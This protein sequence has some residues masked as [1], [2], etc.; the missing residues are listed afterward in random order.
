[1]TLKSAIICG[2]CGGDVEKCPCEDQRTKDLARFFREGCER[3]KA[4]IEA[5]ESQ[6][7]ESQF[8]ELNLFE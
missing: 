3:L 1:M 5:T 4:R 6:K 7:S 2:K 8:I